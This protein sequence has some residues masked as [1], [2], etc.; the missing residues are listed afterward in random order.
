MKITMWVMLIL[1]LIEVFAN[2]LFYINI[3]VG[4]GLV[5]AKKFHGDFPKFASERAWINKIVVSLILGIVALISAFFIYK[6]Y[7]LRIIMSNLFS[8][9]MLI[10]CIVQSVL[11]GKNHVPARLSII[12][13]I[14]LEL[15]VLFQI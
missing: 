1:G 5:Y 9:G 3:K 12:V 4:K 7:D 15:M 11:Y 8:I 6:N 10:L 13:G 14:A 2:L